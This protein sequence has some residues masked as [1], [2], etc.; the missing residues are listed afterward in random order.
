MTFPTRQFGVSVS[1]F[2]C[3]CSSTYKMHMSTSLVWCLNVRTPHAGDLGLNPGLG[4]RSP[5]P[6]LRGCLPQ[7][8]PS[9]GRRKEKPVCTLYVHTYSVHIWK[10]IPQEAET[11]CF[12]P[13][14]LLSTQ[15]PLCH[16][17]NILK[18][19]P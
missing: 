9:T 17:L 6:R 3:L 5:M 16:L 8:R 18:H 15:S 1:M 4:T 2:S 19:L 13:P 10:Y 14:S 11:C 7:L 12:I